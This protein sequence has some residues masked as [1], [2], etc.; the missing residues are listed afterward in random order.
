MTQLDEV[1]SE[2]WEERAGVT[3]VLGVV[4]TSVQDVGL[5]ETFDVRVTL[6]GE[7]EVPLDIE[8][9]DCR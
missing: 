9:A 3:L 2:E 8:S 5:A 4:A 6:D 7:D 1:V